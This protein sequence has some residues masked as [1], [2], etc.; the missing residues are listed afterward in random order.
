MNK[1]IVHTPGYSLILSTTCFNNKHNWSTD[2]C[3][4]A[5]ERVSAFSARKIAAHSP[6]IQFWIIDCCIPIHLRCHDLGHALQC[7]STDSLWHRQQ[8]LSLV[9][10][11]F[12][13]VL[14]LF[15]SKNTSASWVLKNELS[16][17]VYYFIITI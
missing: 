17:L 3:A 6:H 14:K 10:F 4:I 5:V 8:N 15:S 1:K 16:F 12:R 13:L 7:A 9:F 2:N 11:F